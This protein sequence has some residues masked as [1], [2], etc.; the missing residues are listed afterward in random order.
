[1]KNSNDTIGNRSRDL[2]V[3][4]VVPQPQAALRPQLTH[5]HTH[6]H[7][8]TRTQKYTNTYV[9]Y[10]GQLDRLPEAKMDERTRNDYDDDDDDNNNN[11]NKST[12][13]KN[14]H[15]R[16]SARTHTRAHTHTRTRAH[17]RARTHTQRESPSGP[18]P[19]HS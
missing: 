5:T 18:W 17:A 14:N 16:H 9:Q 8:C 3:C 1:M 19:P 11:N 13:Y 12:K 2:P 10:N 4:S 7:S 6:I 15:I